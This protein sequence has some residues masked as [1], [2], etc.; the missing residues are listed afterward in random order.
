[1]NSIE[2]VEG[3]LPTFLTVLKSL[4]PI[5]GLFV[6]FQLAYLRLP[7]SRVF[8]LLKGVG[9]A[10]VG[11]TIFLH[12]VHVGFSPVASEMG[13]MVGKMQPRWALVPF[14]FV[15]GFL[16]TLGEP[17]VRV[18]GDQVEQASGAAIR[19]RV[20]LLT[21]SL[22]VALFVALAMARILYDIELLHIVVPGYLVALGLVWLN[23]RTTVSIAF[24][25]GG[26]A[27]GPM[28]VTFLL[29]MAIGITSAMEGRDVVADGFGLIALIA[30][31][32]ILSIMGLG[33]VVR[34]KYAKGGPAMESDRVLIVTIVRHG[35]GDT[36]LEASIRAGA[37]GGTVMCGRGLGVHEQQKILGIAIEPEKE[38]ALSVVRAEQVD[39]VL[40]GIRKAGKLDEPGTGLAFVVPVEKVVGIVHAKQSE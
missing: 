18:L 38:V 25:A 9:L 12:G 16:A 5:L 27:T 34:M 10:L 24:D 36:V 21:V 3:L 20:V 28:A 13:E 22:G 29:S 30:L 1:L 32:P 23:D 40:E 17:A 6:I 14:G 39:T 33:L 19:K 26:V 35:W 7:W 2:L 31:A 15:M 11:I 4:A 8:A 37:E